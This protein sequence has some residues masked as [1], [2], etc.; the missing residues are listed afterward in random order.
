MKN[1]EAVE[2]REKQKFVAATWEGN[3]IEEG[4]D[5]NESNEFDLGN[6]FGD[7]NWRK[8]KKHRKQSVMGGVGET[9]E[10]GEREK[11]KTDSVISVIYQNWK[12]RKKSGKQ[13]VDR[14]MTLGRGLYEIFLG[15]KK[16][17]RIQ[18]RTQN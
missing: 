17:W 11:R 3:N 16:E 13:K 5:E 10:G 2:K 6:L 12:G 1:Y 15:L 8:S 18:R 14:S 4:K 7:E 9:W